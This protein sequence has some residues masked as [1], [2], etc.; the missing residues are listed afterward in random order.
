MNS[1]LLTPAML[2]NIYINNVRLHVLLGYDALSKES[3]TH[4][5]G[6]IAQ[7]NGIFRYTNTKT[8]TLTQIS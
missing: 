4:W 8:L 2:R 5:H 7:Q 6:I 3:I 1:P